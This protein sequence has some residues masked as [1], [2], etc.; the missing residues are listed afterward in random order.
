MEAA[1]GEVTEVL[2]RQMRMLNGTLVKPGDFDWTSL[3]DHL[4]IRFRIVDGDKELA[5]GKDLDALREQLTPHIRKD[6]RQVAKKQERSGI[7]SWDVGTIDRSIDVGQ[8]TGYP[9]LVDEGNAVAL[10]VLDSKTEQKVGMIR[11]QARLLAITSPSPV[12]NIAKNLDLKAKLTLST[13]P[14]ADGAS[15]IEDCYL[16]AL[17]ELVVRHGG[18]VWDE[19]AFATLRERVR[20]DAYEVAE[21][22]VHSAIKTLM[23]LG[24]ITLDNSEGGED[25]RVQLSWLIYRGFIRD[26][27]VAGMRRIPLYLEAARRRLTKPTTADVLAVQ[28]LEARFH[29][30]TA[31]LNALE[32]LEPRVQHVRWALE[33]L[34][35]S[36]FAQGL[37]TAFPVSVK[38]VTALVEGL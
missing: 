1:A 31:S 10:R 34:R 7:T 18:P 26:A 19:A 8:A 11:G 22:T 24:E 23:A 15:L 32:R 35:L 36:F 20:Q 17:D 28:D 9:A 38:R 13:G 33:E 27:G 14:Y 4:R 21:A 5:A 2:A 37:K 3:P 29:E 30:R 12:V 6:L 16:A 25:V